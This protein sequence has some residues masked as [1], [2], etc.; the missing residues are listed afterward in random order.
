MARV[1]TRAVARPS[2]RSRSAPPAIVRARPGAPN[3]LVVLVDDLAAG[4]DDRRAAELR[5]GRD[6]GSEVLATLDAGATIEVL[7]VSG[8]QVWG[9]APGEGLVG[10]LA[11]DALA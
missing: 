3:I 8:G 1:A 10:Y 9:V 5:A 2:A 4:G 7:E 6:D 11:A